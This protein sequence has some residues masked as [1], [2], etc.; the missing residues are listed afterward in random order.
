MAVFANG[1]LNPHLVT[2]ARMLLRRNRAAAEFRRSII[3]EDKSLHKLA[4]ADISARGQPASSSAGTSRGRN[5]GGSNTNNGT[6]S[7]RPTPGGPAL[8][9]AA[10]AHDSADAAAMSRGSSSGARGRG[11]GRGRPD[12][13]DR[14]QP[15]KTACHYCPGVYHWHAD[16]PRAQ[17]ARDVH[18][19]APLHLEQGNE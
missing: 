5:R 16:C 17:A 11:R 19:A 14:S 10:D 9:A 15:P 4:T 2:K 1:L 18:N 6:A 8:T 12:R 13:Q 7:G 3:A